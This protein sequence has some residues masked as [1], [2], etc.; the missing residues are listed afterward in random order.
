MI[1]YLDNILIFTQ[2]LEKYHKAVCRVLGVLTEH[3]QSL[4]PEKCEFDKIYIR[5]LGLVILED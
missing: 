4:H 2:I 1:V 3:K 5:Y